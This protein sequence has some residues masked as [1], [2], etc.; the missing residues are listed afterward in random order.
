M[1]L[2]SSIQ[3]VSFTQ[4]KYIVHNHVQFS[5][6]AL[7]IMKDSGTTEDSLLMS[8]IHVYI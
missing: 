1:V 3:T 7:Q 6:N 4:I 2:V 5:S 8:I